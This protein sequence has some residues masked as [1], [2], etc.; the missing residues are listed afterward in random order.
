MYVT[1]LLKRPAAIPTYALSDEPFAKVC[2]KSC[3]ILCGA[4]TQLRRQESQD[5]YCKFYH[6]AATNS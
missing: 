4:T 2:F 5:Q 6:V 3:G 1:G